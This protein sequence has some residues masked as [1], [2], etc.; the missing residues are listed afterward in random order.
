[1]QIFD[2][3]PVS[4]FVRSLP[5]SWHLW[6]LFTLGHGLHV[7]KRASLSTTSHLSG[8]RSR[9]EWLRTNALNVA[10]RFFINAT[11]F[12]YW[13]AHPDVATHAVST[14][15]IPVNLTLDPGHA[16]A[17]LFGLS[18]DSMVDWAAAKVPFLQKEIP[19]AASD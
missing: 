4:A 9:F 10:I 13:L 17:A 16:T 18:G 2:I 11:A 8:T 12:S 19:P 1:M 15:G 3:I 7:L 5:E 6:G 14:F